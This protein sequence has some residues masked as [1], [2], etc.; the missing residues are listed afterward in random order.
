MKHPMRAFIFA[1]AVLFPLAVSA[2]GNPNLAGTWTLDRG[3]TPTGRGA[4]GINGS[5]SP[6]R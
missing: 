5:R 6:A 4:G 3:A 2:Q 1:C